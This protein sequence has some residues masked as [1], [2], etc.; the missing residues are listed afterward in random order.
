MSSRA[1]R[2][3]DSAAIEPCRRRMT[4][5]GRKHHFGFHETAVDAKVI[6][7]RG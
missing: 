7:F 6:T 2:L 3:L 5:R 1:G 4:A